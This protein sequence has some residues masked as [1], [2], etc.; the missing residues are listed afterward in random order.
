[1]RQASEGK[2]LEFVQGT[3]I[4]ALETAQRLIDGERYVL[5]FVLNYRGEILHE[6]LFSVTAGEV[7]GDPS[8][9]ETLTGGS[10][11]N[12]SELP[13][14]SQRSAT[15]DSIALDIGLEQTTT[16]GSESVMTG[17]EPPVVEVQELRDAGV[18]EDEDAP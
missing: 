13:D 10:T 1:M 11:F 4:R 9:I 6:Q 2:T 5:W 3:R 17:G 7:G 8:W 12:V 16:G 15:I 18:I 14:A